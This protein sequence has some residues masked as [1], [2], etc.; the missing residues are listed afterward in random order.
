MELST[1]RVIDALRDVPPKPPRKH[2]V[3]INGVDYPVNQA[4]CAATG[5]DPS[6]CNTAVARKKLQKLGFKVRRVG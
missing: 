4:F 3:D 6:D 5:T 1:E 2:V